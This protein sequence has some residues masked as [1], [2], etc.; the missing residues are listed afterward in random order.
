MRGRDPRQH[1]ARGEEARADPQV[2][3]QVMSGL[4]ESATFEV[5][6]GSWIEI[7]PA[8]RR[9]VADDL[10]QRGMTTE[11]MQL[12][13]ELLRPRAPARDAGPAAWPT[14][15]AGND[16]DARPEQVRKVIEEHAESF[17]QPAEMVR[18]FYGQ[19]ERMA[20]VEAL[21]ME[22]NVVEWA[23]SGCRS[24]TSDAVR[25]TDGPTEQ[26]V[27]NANDR[28]RCETN[29]PGR[30]QGLGLIPMVIEQSGPRRARLRH[31]LAP[32]QGARDLPRRPDHGHR[33][34]T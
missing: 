5:P 24:R 34:R 27:G 20:E 13:A 12:P 28:R 22:D 7:E 17:E 23:L 33:R 6:R 3:D 18:W 16:L 21:V 10:K 19:P 15:C 2:K 8:A 9:G 30:P 11:N 26:G 14:S 1:R 4:V 25:R 29:T 31:L 32:A